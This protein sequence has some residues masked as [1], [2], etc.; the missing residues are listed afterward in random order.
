MPENKVSMQ[1]F[2]PVS[3]IKAWREAR[4]TQMLFTCPFAAQ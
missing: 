4:S 2:Y 1:L 3:N